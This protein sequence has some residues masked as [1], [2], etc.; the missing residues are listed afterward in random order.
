MTQPRLIL[1]GGT[2]SSSLNAEGLLVPSGESLD[3]MASEIGFKR[4]VKPYIID[5]IDFDITEHYPK[6]LAAA[7]DALDAGDTPVVCGGTDTLTWYST[8][9]TKDLMRRGYLKDGSDQE[10]I[11][12]TS[13]KS[14]E[15]APELVKGILSAGKVVAEQRNLSGGFA[16]SALGTGGKRVDVHDVTDQ[17]D[18]ISA[19]LI[20]A[21]RSNGPAAFV[22][23]GHISFPEAYTPQKSSPTT[24]K[25]TY[26][27][28][29]PPLLREHDSEAIIAY[30]RR[31]GVSEKPYDG[32]IIEGLSERIHKTDKQNL[33]KIVKALTAAGTRV[34][35]VNPVR[36]DNS[37]HSMTPVLKG[38]NWDNDKWELK[39]A[40]V[41]AGAEFAT[42]LP[43]D[44]YIDMMLGTAPGHAN[45]IT[46][47]EAL[48]PLRN[49]KVMGLRY[50]PDAAL[51]S[52][53]VDTLAPKV[54]AMVFSA[55]PGSVMPDAMLP[56]L[57]RNQDSTRYHSTFEYT[58]NEYIG[59]Q[60]EEI[61]EKPHNGYA[62]GQNAGALIT[63]HKGSNAVVELFGFRHGFMP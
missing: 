58:G 18:K 39:K 61:L 47:P 27:R 59:Q 55:L 45:Q 22:S 5:S 25:T 52:D 10:V 31:L 40:L 23:G 35:F 46:E 41:E 29:A 32:V 26:A 4:S 1:T 44:I 20:N 17:F 34:M 16:L 63:P 38:T 14:I 62:A 8:L 19:K 56:A 48:R 28:I 13:M 6:L 37:V 3:A 24:D 60:G 53:A 57:L 30:L 50:V 2:L 11:F 33:P 43:K 9:L 36:Y 42:G 15:E 54:K 49:Q 51:M 7:R 21:L 12:L